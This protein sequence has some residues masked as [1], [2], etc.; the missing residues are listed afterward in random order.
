MRVATRRREGRKMEIKKSKEKNQPSTQA[1][2][3][4]SLS[5]GS[6][7]RFL[8][9]SE[10]IRVALILIEK[11]GSYFERNDGKADSPL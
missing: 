1:F 9:N 5:N 10:H 8:V 4:L 3:T 2:I 7:S 6:E 11:F